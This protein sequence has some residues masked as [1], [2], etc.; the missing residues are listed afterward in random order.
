MQSQK[1]IFV[2]LV[3]NTP[4]KS[5]KISAL[6]KYIKIAMYWLILLNGVGL[7]QAQTI[8]EFKSKVDD[9]EIEKKIDAYLNEAR[10]TNVYSS[11]TVPIHYTKIALNLAEQAA[12]NIKETEGNLLLGDLYR[13]NN[14]Y[15]KAIITYERA[16]ELSKKDGDSDS[17]SIALNGIGIIYSVLG[18]YSKALSAY[19]QSYLI[20]K[21]NNN[22]ESLA[23]THSNIAGVYSLTGQLDRAS[24]EYSKALEMAKKVGNQ[25]I[26]AEVLNSI[27]LIAIENKEYA[28][29]N[30]YLSE[31]IEI[32][33]TQNDIVGKAYCY[34]NL[35]R[36]F[37]EQGD[38]VNAEKYLNNSLRLIS[39]IEDTG[40]KFTG[41]EQVKVDAFNY[42][43]EIAIANQSYKEA[44]VFF[45]QSLRL[46]KRNNLLDKQVRIYDQLR[47]AHEK[48]NNLKN[49]YKY[50]LLFKS[51]S[52]SLNRA[53]AL[54]KVKEYE[55]LSN[56]DNKERQIS[57]LQYEDLNK[58]RIV[59]AQRNSLIAAFLGLSILALLGFNLFRKNKI[60]ASKNEL[61]EI[62]NEKIKEQNHK[63]NLKNEELKEFAYVVS[64]D[65]KSPLRTIGS[66]AEILN[67][68]YAPKMDS[69]GQEFIKYI[70][71]GT[72]HLQN[73]LEDLLKLAMIG[74]NSN[75]KRRDIDLKDILMVANHF[76]KRDITE[77]DIAIN[78]NNLPTVNGNQTELTQL[79][80]NL[81]G[82]AIKFRDKERGLVID[83]TS[84]D[85]GNFTKVCVADNGIGIPADRLKNI[86]LLFKRAH[87]K[88]EYE[89]TGIGL[90]ICKKIIETNGGKIWVES[91]EGKG[92]SFYFTL[93]KSKNNPST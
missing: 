50:S 47:L 37:N 5:M 6:R 62:T 68:K 32:Y 83:I 43:G 78:A 24:D 11:D 65:L 7:L 31:A 41:F 79:F 85:E 93:P 86:F 75:S 59:K 1:C 81:I 61:L 10:K 20:D 40:L 89:G 29:A 35:V 53:E 66:F 70:V 87:K 72:G 9:F 63:L 26:Q 64:H 19:N 15:Q 60:I 69:D 49:A 51:A 17:E 33:E 52:D 91:E 16:I 30:R 38:I 90:S 21:V 45:N 92:T 80:Q 39:R 8:N 57:Y 28:N 2:S 36:A 27:G 54:R 74:T 73:I 76:Y 71:D 46:A 55:L 44:I 23:G 25:G 13:D 82:N 56:L 3:I 58:Q 34:N 18:D 67:T 48:S 42:K 88:D 14:I 77:F 84:T 12:N 4:N 22:F